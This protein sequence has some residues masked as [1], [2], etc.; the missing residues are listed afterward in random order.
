M[1]KWYDPGANVYSFAPIALLSRKLESSSGAVDP[2]STAHDPESPSR[3]I[4]AQ[5]V[6]TVVGSRY[7]SSGQFGSVHGMKRW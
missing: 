3:S 7:P 4:G 2:G 1:H 5:Y 6:N